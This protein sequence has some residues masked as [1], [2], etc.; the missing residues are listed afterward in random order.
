M[1]SSLLRSDDGAG[2]VSVVL[3]FPVIIIFAQLI[4]FGGRLA[5]TKADVHAAAR[6]AAR[7]ASIAIG[8]STAANNIEAAAMEVL[9]DRGILCGSPAIALTKNDFRDPGDRADYGEG[10]PVVE[11]TVGCQVQ[12]SDLTFLP[13]PASGYIEVSAA[14]L[15]PIDAFRARVPR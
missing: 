8:S 3:I 1:R 13:V 12:V 14:A 2:V 6:E 7:T 5:A 10:G 4:V 9:D 11:V 15:E